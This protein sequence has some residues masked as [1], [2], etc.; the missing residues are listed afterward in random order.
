MAST[1]QMPELNRLALNMLGA[2]DIVG[3]AGEAGVR[4]P[5]LLPLVSHPANGVIRTL[6]PGN[7]GFAVDHCPRAVMDRPNAFRSVAIGL[8]RDIKIVAVASAQCPLAEK[9]AAPRQIA[10]R[11][12]RGASRSLELNARNVRHGEALLLPILEDNHQ[13][14]TLGCFGGTRGKGGQRQEHSQKPKPQH[15]NS[16]LH[17]FLLVEPPGADRPILQDRSQTY[18]AAHPGLFP[19]LCVRLRQ[20][21]SPASF[22]SLVRRPRAPLVCQPG[23]PASCASLR[24]LPLTPGNA[25]NTVMNVA[26]TAIL[27]CHKSHRKTMPVPSKLGRS[28]RTLVR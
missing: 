4:I 14:L 24:S 28:M 1:A 15:S 5:E 10:W 19:V 23:L 12:S 25:P 9:V 2:R 17:T 6:I 21:R 20:P 11:R 3:L 26:L 22:T 8:Q 18:T 27:C 16:L 7:V 13:G